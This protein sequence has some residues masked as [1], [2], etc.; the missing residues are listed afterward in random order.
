VIDEVERLGMI[1]VVS[2]RLLYFI[3]HQVLGLVL[4]MSRT[5]ST[6]VNESHRAP[7]SSEVRQQS[8]QDRRL[9]SSHGGRNG[10]G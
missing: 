6:M 4:L 9:R 3:F 5:S 2:L 1:A 10:D 7:A 8:R